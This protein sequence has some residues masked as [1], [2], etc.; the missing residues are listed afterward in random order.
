MSHSKDNQY[1]LLERHEFAAQCRLRAA[2]SLARISIVRNLTSD[3]C[4]VECIPANLQRGDTI[5]L[6]FGSVGPVEGRV[7]WLRKGMEAG[8]R[9]EQGLHPAVFDRLLYLAHRNRVLSNDPMELKD[10]AVALRKT[11]HRMAAC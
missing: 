5:Y 11:G 7:M 4:A 9:F 1:R 2:G 3:G 8:I 6:Q 10:D